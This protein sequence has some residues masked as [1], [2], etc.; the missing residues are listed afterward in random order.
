LFLFVAGF[1]PRHWDESYWILLGGKD[2]PDSRPWDGSI[3]DLWIFDHSVNSAEAAQLLKG[4]IPAH[5][6]TSLIADYP[7]SGINPLGERSGSLPGLRP[8]SKPPHFD[9]AGATFHCGTSLTSTNP[10]APIAISVN[11]SGQF[12]IVLTVATSDLQ[13]F[14]PSRI[15]S[16]AANAF[17][18][19]LT[20]GQTRTAL[21]L[22]WRSF[23]TGKNG[24]TPEIEF[25]GIFR[26]LKPQRLVVSFDGS[27]A[28]IFTANPSADSALWLGP[29]TGF[30]A[31]LREGAEWVIPVKTLTIW[32]S[33]VIFAAFFYLPAG[34]LAAL[35]VLFGAKRPI[36]LCATLAFSLPEI[37]NSLF[38]TSQIRAD[39]LALNNSFIVAGYIFGAVAPKGL[40]F[41]EALGARCSAF[42]RSNR[43]IE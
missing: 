18:R 32:N 39:I 43:T 42:L 8:R 24:T 7:L 30:T 5:M 27:E 10:V 6:S 22:R 26:S 15:V 9:F 16:I 38:W 11:R 21:S 33:G 3:R 28:K 2:D 14:G 41:K 12:S 20:L 17:H 4:H 1:H 36:V 31:I 29:E 37:V 23:L 34:F 40:A 35:A 13:Q 25:P 19:N